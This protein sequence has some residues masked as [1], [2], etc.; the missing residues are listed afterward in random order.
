M[1]S[2]SL[3]SSSRRVERTNSTEPDN[4]VQL[5][6]IKN[7]SGLVPK[8]KTSSS[9]NL[10]KQLLSQSVANAVAI[11]ELAKKPQLPAA[12]LLQQSTGSRQKVPRSASDKAEILEMTDIQTTIEE[13]E[14]L[15]FDD[16]N[17]DAIEVAED[18]V[19]DSNDADPYPRLDMV[20]LATLALE[21]RPSMKLLA[22][23]TDLGTAIDYYRDPNVLRP[24]PKSIAEMAAVFHQKSPKQRARALSFAGIWPTRFNLRK[25]G[26]HGRYAVYQA[27]HTMYEHAW[28]TK[29]SKTNWYKVQ[30][31]VLSSHIDP[32][33][34]DDDMDRSEQLSQHDHL[35]YTFSIRQGFIFR[36][37]LRHKHQFLSVMH[38]MRVPIHFVDGS[39]GHDVD[40]DMDINND[41]DA[42]KDSSIEDEEN[43]GIDF[44][45]VKG[46]ATVSR[47][48][49]ITTIDRNHVVNVW[50]LSKLGS[51]KPKVTHQ[52]E[53]EI[54]HL[55]FLTKHAMY[56]G[57]V[58]KS[59][60][61]SIF[62][63]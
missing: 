55:V 53:Y 33:S 3:S 1:R 17:K 54:T 2:S 9:S 51:C 28:L 16:S 40:K 26:M 10:R 43:D 12:S 62:T 59:I 44:D 34:L 57:V 15:D 23:Q 31:N 25:T 46:V 45:D 27:A 32:A 35:P 37:I 18:S 4:V 21:R 41:N 50:D 19:C 58:D 47:P 56:A 63:L 13:E 42:V 7:T 49:S 60:K 6:R 11:A 61:V 8:L 5:Q 48:Y 52:M 38:H 36:A 14:T 20:A 30:S 24:P 39:L 22:H 29:R